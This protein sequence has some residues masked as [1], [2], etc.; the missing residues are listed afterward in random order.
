MRAPRTSS[1]AGRARAR[2][3]GR[4]RRLL[5]GALISGALVAAP[6]PAAAGQATCSS[7]G[8]PVGAT[9]SG[10]LLPGRLILTLNNGFLPIQSDE[11][12][13]ET[14]GLVRYDTRLLFV[15]SRLGAEYA[16]TPWLALS[17]AFSY[18]VIDVD[19]QH[20]DPQ[21]G[22]VILSPSIHVRSERLHGPGDATI[23]AH[24]AREL[25]G[26]RLHARFGT[27]L[28]LGRTEENPHL[29]GSLGQEHQHLQLGTGTWIPYLAI[30]AQVPLNARL[31]VAG[32]A[33]AQPSLY[34]NDQGFRA[35]TRYSG[36]LSA[37][38][39]LGQRRWTLS[40]AAEGHGETA[41]RWDGRVYRDEGNAGRFDL[42]VGGAAT[43]RATSRLSI[44]TD[45]KYAAAS[46][47]EGSQLDYGLVASVGVAMTFDLVRR[48]SWRGL[49]Q[50]PAG[51][52]GSA[53]EL[54]PVAGRITVFDLWAEWCA[55]C[56]ELDA[57]L[58]A[59][60]RAYPDRLAVR[61]LD[62]VN[63]ESAAWQRYL[64]PQGYALPHLKVY[65]ANGE[66]AFERTASPAELAAAIE[67][68]L[69]QP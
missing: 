27:S 44:T 53:P 5:G 66:L 50:R 62:V 9:A 45:L 1:R 15:E 17:A 49:D 52:A 55:P 61:K 58:A 24:L 8:L 30:E 6:S 10:E 21:S 19:L 63:P 57:R 14:Q 54:V 16:L 18:R 42:L 60:A 34:Q 12:I 29:L 51:P 69:R 13:G 25:R 33:L 46:R 39:P 43:W 67:Q 2:R 31:T 3:G 23:G 26:V 40:L 22:A 35:S 38:M 20:R 37:A 7:P 65:A 59:L 32:W 41:E 68:L 48:P 4:R 56:R 28:P 36:G 11:L 47:V 64:G